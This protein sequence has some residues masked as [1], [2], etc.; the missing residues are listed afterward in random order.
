MSLLCK[1]NTLD[2]SGTK[3]TDESV[4]E[5]KNCHTLVLSWTKITDESVKELRLSGCIVHK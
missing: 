2:L 5:L 3:I 1:R 4:K